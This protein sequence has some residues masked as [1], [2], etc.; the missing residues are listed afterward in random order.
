MSCLLNVIDGAD[1]AECRLLIMTTNCPEKLDKALLRPGRCD[2]KFKI[3]Y[4]TKTTARLTSKRIFGLDEQ[5]PYK[6]A[7]IDRFA[8]AFVAQFPWNSKISIAE[9]AKYLGQYRGRPQKAIEDFAEWTKRGID[10]FAYRVDEL[11]SNVV[12]GEYNVPEPYEL[13]LLNVGPDDLVDVKSVKSENKSES[14]SQGEKPVQSSWNPF[15]WRRT[16]QPDNTASLALELKDLPDRPANE[17][18]FLESFIKDQAKMDVP[19]GPS[20][21]EFRRPSR[22]AQAVSFYQDLG[23]VSNKDGAPRKQYQEFSDE[24]FELDDLETELRGVSPRPIEDP[25]LSPQ[26]TSE[27][28]P[29]SPRAS[30][31]HSPVLSDEFLSAKD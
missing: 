4:A 20:F 6:P 8:E 29:S 18:S 30:S 15:R 25:P 24:A 7:T 2:E 9:L 5:T 11:A 16:P 3:D 23:L 1:A 10:L 12:H 31:A 14:E 22:Q 28:A 17:P 26:A 19:A 13:S 27:H 21:E